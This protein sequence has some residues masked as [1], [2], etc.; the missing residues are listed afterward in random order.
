VQV[1]V[2]A[3][4]NPPHLVLELEKAPEGAALPEVTLMLHRM[5]GATSRLEGRPDA[6]GHLAG[7]QV[8]RRQ[9][10]HP[11]RVRWLLVSGNLAAALLALAW[12]LW[13]SSKHPATEI[14]TPAPDVTVS[15]TV[16]APTAIGRDMPRQ[17]FPG[18][19]RA[20][21]TPRTHVEVI[22]A[23]WVLMKLPPPCP[24]D[25]VEHKGE[26]LMPVFTAPREPA[27]VLP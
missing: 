25:V 22:G 4:T 2:S 14:S 6:E 8:A 20:P 12:W 3:G 15:G 5:A 23:C 13:P 19:K 26:C 10:R 11:A 9:R 17:P 18:Q 24:E 16:E 1:R 7:R 21:C 27:S